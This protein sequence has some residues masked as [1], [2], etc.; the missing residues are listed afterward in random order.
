MDGHRIASLVEALRT[1]A[2]AGGKSF[3]KYDVPK[4]TKSTTK[5]TIQPDNLVAANAVTQSLKPFGNRFNYAEMKQVFAKLCDMFATAWKLK[6]EHRADWI[7]FMVFR[8]RCITVKTYDATRKGPKP[9]WVK[10]LP[11]NG[12]ETQAPDEEE[13]HNQKRRSAEL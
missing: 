2:E 1:H 9:S 13:N 5:A 12:E 6:N 7:E 10:Q 8:C 3:I 4:D 11:W